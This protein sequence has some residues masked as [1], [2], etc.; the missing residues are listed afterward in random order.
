MSSKFSLST[1][2]W[3]NSFHFRQTSSNLGLL[4]WRMPIFHVVSFTYVFT[5]GIKNSWRCLICECWLF[6]FI[7]DILILSLKKII[8]VDN[9]KWFH[10]GKLQLLLLSIFIYKA[11]M[12]YTEQYNSQTVWII[13]SRQNPIPLTAV[14]CLLLCLRGIGQEGQRCHSVGL[15][16]LA[17]TVL[18]ERHNAQ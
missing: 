14:A 13:S 5:A 9:L 2:K 3:K 11:P 16:Q 6:D 18:C 12:Y 1:Y 10:T 15:W 4:L 7:V 17:F 8:Y